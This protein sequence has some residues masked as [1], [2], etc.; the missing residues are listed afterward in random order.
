MSKED[1]EP[2]E[3]PYAWKNIQWWWQNEHLNPNG[4]KTGWRPKMKKIWF[5]E[6][7][8]PSVDGASNQPNVFFDPESIESKFPNLSMGKVDIRS[9]RLGLTATELAWSN[10]EMIERKFIWTWDARPYPYW[11]DNR[12]IW[13]DGINW[14][15]GHWL[16]GK[17][18]LITLDTIVEDL[19]KKV[20]L[21]SEYIDVTLLAI[22]V[23]GYAITSQISARKAIELLQ[24][25]YFFDCVESDGILKFIPRDNSKSYNILK[26][27]LLRNSDEVSSNIIEITRRH[28]LELPFKTS[29]LFT[30]KNSNY[31]IAIETATQ[32]HSLSKEKEFI[33][34]PLALDSSYAKRVAEI[35]NCNAWNERFVYNFSLPIKYIYLQ[36]SDIVI[37]KLNEKTHVIRIT[38][39]ELTTMRILNIKGTSDDTSLY[40]LSF[41]SLPSENISLPST[42][43][44]INSFSL[45]NIIAYKLQSDNR[46]YLVLGL[47]DDRFSNQFKEAYINLRNKKSNENN[48][49]QITKLAIF[50]EISTTENDLVILQRGAL[51]IDQKINAISGN[52]LICIDK[53]VAQDQF[54][55]QINSMAMEGDAISLLSS[56]KDDS[57]IVLDSSVVQ[58]ELDSS[59][60]GEL[61]ELEVIFNDNIVCQTT[62]KI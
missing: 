53:V 55:Y 58:I 37:L 56:V 51:P 4:K 27:D 9:Q 60:E 15:T 42:S 10:S 45:S 24:Q 22:P 6:Y 46:F 52:K 28:E 35:A 48:L 3:A 11:P 29:V 14:K 26:E 61:F 57:F 49:F 25:A 30:D 16:N 1:S 32:F 33:E 38:H 44:F 7:G 21:S 13:R 43:S 34:L 23:D 18:G 2:L 50:G 41:R 12:S 40:D 39:I 47:I 59:L 5:T 20:G 17:L 8:F 54:I 31:R 62:I 19:C 36:P